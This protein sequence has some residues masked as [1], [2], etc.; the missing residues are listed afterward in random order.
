MNETKILLVTGK[1]AKELVK[2]YSKQSDLKTE[3]DALPIEI[4]SFMNLN[5]FL[6]GLED[7][8]LEPFSMILVPG[9]AEFD[10][11]KA[12]ETLGVPVFKGPKHAAD[13]PFVL[14]NFESLNLFKEIPAAEMLEEKISKRAEKQLEKIKKE[15]YEK[16]TENSN[17]KV[18]TEE[19]SVLAGPDFPLK[20]VAEIIDA[21]NLPKNRLL[22]QA[23][24]YLENGADILDIGMTTEEERSEEIP[25]IISQLRNNF[26]VP[27]SID[28]TDRSEIE[29]ALAEGIDMIISIDGSTIEHFS[30]LDVPSVIIPRKSKTGSIIQ[31]PEERV[32]KLWD[33]IEKAIDLGYEKPIP[34]PILEPVNK[35]FTNSLSAFRKMRRDDPEIPLFMGVGNV[36]ELFDADSIGMTA[37]LVGMASELDISFLLSVEASDKTKRNV[38]EMAKARDMMLLAERRNS[39]P[40]NLGIDL[41]QLKQKRLR[42]DP[43]D[44]EIEKHSEIIEASPSKENSIQVG[45][46]FKISVLESRIVAVFHSSKKPNV[47]IKGENAEEVCREILE[48]GLVEKPSHAAYLGRELQKAEV[49]LRTGRGYVQEEKIFSPENRYPPREKT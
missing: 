3:V 20:I 9:Q 28:T 30:G 39:V 29:T 48:K 14:E 45:K 38:S 16:M 26:E 24:H 25:R 41:L 35:G 40:K 27:L 15:T 11:Q 44:E 4:A 7:R 1:Q 46:Y 42:F 34:D 2:K 47:V 32:K 19:K 21:P 37:L 23:A 31:K 17:F 13:I 8:D 10:L 5:T 18:G 36:I 33:L 12:E 49:A 22:E 43:Y 6:K